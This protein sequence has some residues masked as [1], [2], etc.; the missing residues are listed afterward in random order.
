MEAA[1]LDA[2]I[3]VFQG[4]SVDVGSSMS[5]HNLR[6]LVERKKTDWDG[7]SRWFNGKPQEIYHDV[8]EKLD[9]HRSLL[10]M[11]PSQEKYLSILTGAINTLASVSYLIHDWHQA[12]FRNALSHWSTWLVVQLG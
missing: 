10:S 4:E 3:Q 2:A 8:L 9:A 7:K 6:S 5:L 1:R 12:A 11:L